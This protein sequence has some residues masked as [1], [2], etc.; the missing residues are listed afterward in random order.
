MIDW[1]SRYS[2]PGNLDERIE[3]Q[4]CFA[5][6]SLVTLADGKQKIIAD[7]HSGDQILAFDDQTKQIIPT[8][9]LT[10]LDNQPDQF[11]KSPSNVF[12]DYS[13]SIF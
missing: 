13:H 5:A 2:F 11:G 12:S 9:V 6:D 4:R 3:R 1:K 10:M 8:K 7:L